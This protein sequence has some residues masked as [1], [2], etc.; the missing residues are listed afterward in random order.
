MDTAMPLDSPGR[1]TQLVDR[2]TPWKRMLLYVGIPLVL[3]VIFGIVSVARAATVNV[4]VQGLAFAP[5][6]VTVAAGDTVVWTNADTVPHTVTADAAGGFNQDLPVGGTTSLVFNTPGTF[7]YRCNVHPSMTG[8]V[9]VQAAGFLV[10]HTEVLYDLDVE[11]KQLAAR[12]GIGF[13]RAACVHDHP[14]YIRLLA[15]RVEQAFAAIG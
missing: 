15:D 12:L 11:A 5:Q 7:A 6:S 4:N 9:V 2:G 10:D 14:A 3:A 8:T 13:T 1:G